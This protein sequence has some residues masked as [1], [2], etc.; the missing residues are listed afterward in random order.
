MENPLLTFA[1][2][3]IIVGD[4]SS[5]DVVIHE[6]AHSWSGNLFSCKNWNSFWLNEGMNELLK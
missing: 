1:S 5:T 3:S 4:K 2:P 6:M